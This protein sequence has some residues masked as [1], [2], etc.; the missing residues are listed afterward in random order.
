MASRSSSSFSGRCDIRSGV[1]VFGIDQTKR[2]KGATKSVPSW[3]KKKKYKKIKKSQS[4]LSFFT[5]LNIHTMSAGVASTAALTSTP[6]VAGA[7]KKS[8]ADFLKLV[9]GRPVVVKLNSGITYQGITP[10]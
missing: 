2:Q 4:S 8:P 10:F 3:K 7:S 6:A 9:L 5:H 1:L